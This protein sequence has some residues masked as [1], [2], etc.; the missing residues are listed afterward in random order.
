MLLG[1]LTGILILLQR[2]M[3]GPNMMLILFR[4]IA[5]KCKLPFYHLVIKDSEFLDSCNTDDCSLNLEDVLHFV[6]LY[7]GKIQK[8]FKP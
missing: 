3:F 1:L 2:N 6:L 8:S 4:S 7:S 5:L